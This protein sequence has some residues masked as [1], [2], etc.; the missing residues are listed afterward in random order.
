MCRAVS[1]SFLSCD[2]IV[3]CNIR[4]TG[5]LVSRSQTYANTPR[6]RQTCDSNRLQSIQTPFPVF[7]REI[8]AAI[9]AP[10]AYSP[11]EISVTA[12]PTLD[13]GRSGSPVLRTC[14]QYM[15][16]S[17]PAD[18]FYPHVHKPCFTLDHDVISRRF[19]IRTRLSIA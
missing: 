7:W 3:G 8:R 17:C 19:S 9:M 14:G 18:G 13:G 12:T 1:I 6:T 5:K 16:P 4:E 2:E 10:W 15:V 11:V